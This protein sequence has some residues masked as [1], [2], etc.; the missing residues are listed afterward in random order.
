MEELETGYIYLMT[1]SLVLLVM[2]MVA[3][4]NLENQQLLNI[5]AVY[6]VMLLSP[7]FLLAL[8]Y[9][10]TKPAQTL[11]AFIQ[12]ISSLCII[13]LIAGFFGSFKIWGM[14]VVNQPVPYTPQ[15]QT[16]SNLLRTT[17]PVVLTLLMTVPT[18]VAEESF[19]RIFLLNVLTPLIKPRYALLTQAV[20]FGIMHWWAYG[21]NPVSIASAIAAG[22]ALG[23]IY[24]KTGS[25]L[26]ISATHAIYNLTIILLSTW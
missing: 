7:L 6:T 26:A 13:S 3:G 12:G 22:I 19:F 16:L 9:E 25:E 2:A 23:A 20:V 8:G 11:N 18:A 14:Y 4:A 10:T 1:L 15:L 24:Q 5:G 21:L 17:P